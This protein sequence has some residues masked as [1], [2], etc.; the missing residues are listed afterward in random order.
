MNWLEARVDQLDVDSQQRL[1]TNPLRILDSK[2][3]TT[4]ALLED[5]PTLFNVLSDE[6][7]ERFE[8]V[9]RFLSQLAIPCGVY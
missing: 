3:P 8:A 1:S 2:N 9:Q 6:G 7:A 4:Q 5:A